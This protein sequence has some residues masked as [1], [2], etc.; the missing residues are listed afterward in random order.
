MS[1]G[2]PAAFGTDRS[3]EDMTAVWLC[4]FVVFMTLWF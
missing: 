2:N 4:L 3:E 1:R